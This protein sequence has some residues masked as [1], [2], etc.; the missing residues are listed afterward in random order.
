MLLIPPS[1]TSAAMNGMGTQQ[2]DRP[3]HQGGPIA[4]LKRELRALLRRHF[5]AALRDVTRKSQISAAEILAIVAHAWATSFDPSLIAK[6]NADVGYYIN[7]DGYLQY[8]LTRLLPVPGA[9]APAASAPAA[10]STPAA[11]AFASAS[12]DD[13]LAAAAAAAGATLGSPA[14]ASGSGSA[15]APA[16]A[17]TRAL[18]PAPVT[19]RAF[20]RHHYNELATSQSIAV[21]RARADVDMIVALE[22]ARVGLLQPVVALPQQKIR[23]DGESLRHTKRGCVVGSDDHRAAV[24]RAADNEAAAARHQ[25]ASEAAK[26]ARHR[27]V[28]LKAEAALVDKNGDVSG[29]NATN[30]KALV[31]SRTGRWPKA[32]SFKDGSL[33]AA[34]EAAARARNATLMPSTP[35][36]DASGRISDGGGSGD[37]AVAAFGTDAWA[38]ESCDAVFAE[39]NIPAPDENNFRWCSCG[40]PV[41]RA[42]DDNM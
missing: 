25:L 13:Q 27:A 37:E 1:H 15:P 19:S 9:H 36:A 16:A 35:P 32:A 40:A 33:L 24:G 8:D 7:E 18:A 17:P 39:S 38:C 2:G 10:A 42:A 29:L 23:R 34:A 11:A 6:L 12:V 14:T 30:L 41:S 22:R 4:R 20:G 3:A 21:E 31:L 26:W 28:V 5:G